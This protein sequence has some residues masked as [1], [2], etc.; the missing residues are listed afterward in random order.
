MIHMVSDEIGK[1]QYPL[2]H[3]HHTICLESKVLMVK[4][5]GW[6]MWGRRLRA[7][8]KEH[9][10]RGVNLASKVGISESGL[11]SWINGNREI[12]LSDFF[13]LCAAA[14]ADPRIILFGNVGLTIEQKQAL[15]Q[16]VVEILE[17]DPTSAP[18]YPK[19]VTQL[20]ADINHRRTRNK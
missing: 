20:Q 5:A 1:S 15:G 12:N 14:K 3:F 7:H 8:M 6:G 17:A 2:N 4:D 13:N 11:R 16:A 18:G 10:Q 9:K 19:L